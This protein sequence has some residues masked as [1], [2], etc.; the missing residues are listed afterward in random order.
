MAEV[1]RQFEVRQLLK[2]YRKGL[3][4]DELFAEQMREIETGTPMDGPGNAPAKV[5]RLRKRTFTS[6]RDLLLRFLDEFRAGETFGGET[7]ALW[8][9]NTCNATL[10]G[11]LRVVAQ[12][13]AT[14][15][16]LLETRLAELGGRCEVTLP[17]TFREAARARLS[18]R[19]VSDLDKL[20]DLTRRLPDVEAAVQPIRDVI[21]Q[22][23]EDCETRTLLE[24]LIDEETSTLRW[25]H[26]MEKCLSE[27]SSHARTEKAA[28]GSAAERGNGVAAPFGS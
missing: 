6:E 22:I 11:G 7:F 16:R 13:E 19:D 17:E 28:A 15:G 12:R 9:E 23:E 8:C 14:H 27:A 2:A 10:R 3:I 25:L 1:N 4:S 5:Y 20:R 18:A 24:L 21:A 26:A